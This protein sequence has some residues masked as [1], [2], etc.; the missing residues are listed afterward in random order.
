[1]DASWCGAE[2]EEE[3]DVPALLERDQLRGECLETEREEQERRSG[4]CA[5]R[6][7]RGEREA[8]D[9]DEEEEEERRV[10]EERDECS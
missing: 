9:G 7:R 1:M 2:I 8:E 5:R 3:D 4:G 10:G 6:M